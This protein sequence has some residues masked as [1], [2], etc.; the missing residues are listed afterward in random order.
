MYL[1]NRLELSFRFVL[2]FPKA[3][4]KGFDWSNKLVTLRKID[5]LSDISKY[6][7]TRIQESPRYYTYRMRAPLLS[8]PNKGR[9][10]YCITIFK[11]TSL[12]PLTNLTWPIYK[13]IFFHFGHQ[14]CIL[15]P[16][17]YLPGVHLS[18]PVFY[19]FCS[20]A[21]TNDFKSSKCYY[22]PFLTPPKA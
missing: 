21:Y 3:S 8:H 12:A 17:I 14:A 13:G 6:I 4:S 19:T 1:P 11:I 20:S 7:I 22:V 18:E 5:H 15:G 16:Y 10:A 9:H 2:A